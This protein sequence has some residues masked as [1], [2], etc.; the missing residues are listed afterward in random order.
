MRV[1]LG[2]RWEGILV[3]ISHFL[4][5]FQPSSYKHKPPAAPPSVEG[6]RCE[7][8]S[9]SQGWPR[10]PY[11]TE[12]SC[13]GMSSDRRTGR[14]SPVWRPRHLGTGEGPGESGTP[15]YRGRSSV[16]ECEVY[17]CLCVI[18][19]FMYKHALSPV[20]KV[21]FKKYSDTKNKEIFTHLAFTLTTFTPLFLKL[22][23]L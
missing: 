18:V 4:I 5:K 7:S 14:R 22:F 6:N 23:W 21:A 15:L 11:G 9:R 3:I 13:V 12:P 10:D 8:G 16:R 2:D 1:R 17:V 19:A 20:N